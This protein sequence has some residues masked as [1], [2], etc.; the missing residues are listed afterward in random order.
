MTEISTSE[1]QQRLE[2]FFGNNFNV[3]PDGDSGY[4]VH[5]VKSAFPRGYDVPAEIAEALWGAINEIFHGY[6]SDKQVQL[7]DEFRDTGIILCSEIVESPLFKQILDNPKAKEYLEMR[8]EQA[9]Q[10]AKNAMPLSGCVQIIPTF[11]PDSGAV[12][13]PISP[14]THEQDPEKLES[15]RQ[16]QTSPRQSPLREILDRAKDRF[17]RGASERGL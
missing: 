3:I 16:P 11:S 17:N 14:A 9:S 12:T 2:D 1:N 7:I 8:I 15:H 5:V 10:R 6:G 4:S 13:D